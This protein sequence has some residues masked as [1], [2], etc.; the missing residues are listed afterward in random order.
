MRN[1][2][3]NRKNGTASRGRS[4]NNTAPASTQSTTD[5][6]SCASA[7]RGV[8]TGSENRPILSGERRTRVTAM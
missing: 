1:A 4:T 5:T 3:M 8:G 7:T 6:A 2:P